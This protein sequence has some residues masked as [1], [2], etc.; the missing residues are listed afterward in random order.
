M[1]FLA[2]LVPGALLL[3]QAPLAGDILQHVWLPLVHLVGLTL[4]LLHLPVALSLRLTLLLLLTWLLPAWAGVESPAGAWIQRVLGIAQ[5]WMPDSDG[6]AMRV[7]APLGWD[8]AL[9]VLGWLLLGWLSTP[10]TLHPH[11]IRDPR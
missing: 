3:S 2:A 10:I 7:S 8:R 11:A 9:T 6:I 4:V 5:A 1:P